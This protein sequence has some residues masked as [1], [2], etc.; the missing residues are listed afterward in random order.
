MINIILLVI[1]S[2]VFSSLGQICFK[3]A[4]NKTQPMRSKNVG[5]YLTYIGS[6][7]RVGWVWLGLVSMT[8]SLAIWLLAVAQADLSLVYPI[9]SLY[10]IFVLILARLFLNERLD[11]MKILGTLFIFG[12][13]L[14]IIRS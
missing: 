6:V 4:S 10:Y 2:A 8:V 13:I 14:L 1:L 12:G 11:R 7:L 9:G 5:A 3:I